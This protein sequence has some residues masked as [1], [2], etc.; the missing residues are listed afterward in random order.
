MNSEQISLHIKERH[1]TY[2]KQFS[3]EI[4]DDKIINEWL[5]L[6]NWAPNHKLTEPWR[7]IV[8][9]GQS[10]IDLAE[11]FKSIYLDKTPENEVTN[12]KLSKFELFKTHT[13]HIL[14][15]YCQLDEAKRLPEW[16]E[17]A[18]TSMAVQNLY[19]A[20]DAFDICGYWGTGNTNTPAIREYLGLNEGQI[21]MGWLFLGKPDKSL[22]QGRRIRRPM[23]SKVVW[24]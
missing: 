5:E 12:A 3:G 22:P 9:S 10:R 18:A 8:L 1:S 15:V 11:K 2:P 19:L 7:F 6:A 13:S 4:I 21:H 16:E 24:K 17:I 20:M 23:E 14:A